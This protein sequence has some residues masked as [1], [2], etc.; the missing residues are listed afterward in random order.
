MAQD[1]TDDYYRSSSQESDR[2]PRYGAISHEGNPGVLNGEEYYRDHLQQQ[3]PNQPYAQPQMNN[4]INTGGNNFSP[5]DQFYPSQQQ[6]LPKRGWPI[7]TIIIGFVLA[8]IVS[9]VFAF[10]SIAISVVNS[11]P[12]DFS[13]FGESVQ[14]NRPF[15]IT[16]PGKKYVAITPRQDWDCHLDQ[17][18]TKIP[19]KK[20][21]IADQNEVKVKDVWLGSVNIQKAGTYSLECTTADKST[22]KEIHVFDSKEFTKLVR[23]VTSGVFWGLGVGAVLF[24]VG[25]IIGIVGIVWLVRRNRERRQIS[26]RNAYAAMPH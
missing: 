6:E 10:S 9:P 2:Q 22:P 24:V 17:T 21:K 14:S 12:Q 7:A 26:M 19:V 1:K 5:N 8:L 18:G 20:D 11:L 3:A 25:I 4:G 13:H 16:T 15:Q 23:S